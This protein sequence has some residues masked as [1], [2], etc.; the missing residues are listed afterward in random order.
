MSTLGEYLRKHY[1]WLNIPMYT[2][3]WAMYSL[4]WAMYALRKPQ[5]PL[6]LK[7]RAHNVYIKNDD[8]RSKNNLFW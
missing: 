4:Q 3:Q 6:T 5:Y 7:K 1:Y 8:V 2:L